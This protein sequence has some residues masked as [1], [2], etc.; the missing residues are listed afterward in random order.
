MNEKYSDTTPTTLAF[1]QSFAD[2]GEYVYSIPP[3]AGS[4]ATDYY[5]LYPSRTGPQTGWW[6]YREEPDGEET[7]L[8][9]VSTLG[10]LRLAFHLFEIGH[11]V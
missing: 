4:L 5:F 1:V 7:T 6:L 8:V 3:W 10:R 9:D 11:D 2:R